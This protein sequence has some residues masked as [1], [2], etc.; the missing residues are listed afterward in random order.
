M[1]PNCASQFWRTSLTT[2]TTVGTG[3]ARILCLTMSHNVSPH[4]CTAPVSLERV[5]RS[6]EVAP[7]L[8]APFWTSAQYCL[9]FPYLP[10]Q[11]KT[12]T[13]T[14]Y[15]VQLR[16]HEEPARMVNVCVFFW[17]GKYG[18]SQ[19]ILRRCPEG[20]VQSWRDFMRT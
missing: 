4:H 20:S 15:K 18:E 8:D 19:A 6:H 14:M 13:L 1:L 7:A 3:L 2:V 10:R 12:Q 16:S 9:R 5:L 11:K 17:R